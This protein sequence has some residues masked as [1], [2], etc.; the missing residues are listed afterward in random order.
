[1]NLNHAA[2]RGLAGGKSFLW[3]SE[4]AGAWQ[5]ER[6]S[7]GGALE[8]V[9]VPPALGW[10]E[11][12]AVDEAAGLVWFHAGAEPTRQGLWRVPLAGGEPVPIGPEAGVQ[13]GV[14]GRD[15][16]VLTGASL[17]N[18]PRSVVWRRDGS[19]AGELP[20]AAEEPAAWPTTEI[21]RVGVGEGW[22]ARLTR[23][24][25]FVSGRKYPV[26]VDVYGGPHAQVVR[27]TPQAGFV[28]QWLAD[29]GF[30]VVALDGR[31]TPGRG[32][33]W[34]RALA[35]RLGPLPLA[36]Q[37]AALAALGER[38]P[39]LDLTRVGIAGWSFGGYLSAYA[40]ARRPDVF[41]AAVAGAPVTDWYD[42]DT[43]YTERYLGVPPAA[44]AAYRESSV[45][46]YAAELA[47]PLLLI[48]GTRDDNV[49]FRHTLRLTDR[50]VRAGRPF[51]VLPLPGFT[52]MLPDPAVAEQRWQR[53][54]EFFRRHLRPGE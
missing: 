20:S 6:R 47:R 38:F 11:L 12:V 46:T 15:A 41:H 44:D 42:Y 8:Q 40:V 7:A 22:Y 32:R 10:R 13:T 4:R 50:L 33:A 23:P 52:H 17:T 26:I 30:V 28:A 19:V 21:V 18:L 43:H 53:T 48:H 54:R 27:A 24:R 45:L 9:L 29:A 14:V 37:A 1:V 31:G 2:P 35:G 34:E 39:E 36:E 16:W 49:F 3:T 25:A 5:L 51:E